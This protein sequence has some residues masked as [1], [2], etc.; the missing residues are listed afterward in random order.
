MRREPALGFDGGEVLHVPADEPAQVLHEPVDQ[1]GEVDRVPRG[2]D[3]VVP[4]RVDRRPVAADRAVRVEGG[5]DEQ[6]RPEPLA[7]DPAHGPRVDP[8]ARE[9]GDVLPPASR[10]HP[11]RSCTGA[12]PTA[13]AG[14]GDQLVHLAD[15]R[16]DF[17]RVLAGVLGVDPGGFQVRP[18]RGQR[19][20]LGR[21]RLRVL[22]RLGVE[23]PALPALRD[24]Q[25]PRPLRT[26]RALATPASPR[27]AGRPARP[28][29]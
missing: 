13:D 2:A 27:T 8:A 18:Y 17:G 6:R 14:L 11:P 26:R 7:V 4:V 15:D 23:V 3:V 29:R 1:P 24:P 19:P 12:D 28:R 16:L 10:P 5:G 25:P 9:V 20:L 21:R 22:D